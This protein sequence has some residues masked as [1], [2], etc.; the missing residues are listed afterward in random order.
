M[1]RIEF[2]WRKA[3]LVAM[4]AAMWLAVYGQALAA[5]KG[6][7]SAPAPDAGGAAESTHGWVL[8]YFL[9]LLAIGLGMLVVCRSSRRSDRAK[10]KQYEGLDTSGK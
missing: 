1:S 10:P 8:P 2:F 4:A 9:L 6:K 3:K 7:K 5:G